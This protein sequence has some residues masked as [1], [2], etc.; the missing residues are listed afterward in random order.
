[1]GSNEVITVLAGLLH[2]K[3]QYD[4]LRMAAADGLGY[5]GF[6]SAREAL[7]KTV[8]DE[9]ESKEIRVVAIRALGRTLHTAK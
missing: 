6:S 1:M 5:G 9:S 2:D 3:G 8:Q 7:L 4:S